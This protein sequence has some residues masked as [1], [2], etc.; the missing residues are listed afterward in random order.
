MVSNSVA[1]QRGTDPVSA[2]IQ[3]YWGRG[4]DGRP[5]AFVPD[6]GAERHWFGN[7][8]RVGDR[9]LLFLNRVRSTHT[10]IGFESTG[11][12]AW[13]VENP[14]VE[15]S[16]WRMRRLETPANPVGVLLGFAAV[17]R[18][19]EYVIALGSADPI[20]SHPIY[21]ARWPAANVRQGQLQAPEWWAGYRLGWVSDASSV[22][23]WPLFENGQSELSLHLDPATGRFLA[24][25]TQGFG[26]A[27]V[28]MRA[29]PALTGPWSAPRF[30]FRPP[31]YVRPNAMIYAAKAHPE[32]TG[33]DLT[34]TYATN[35]FQFAEHLTDSLIYYPRFVRVVRSR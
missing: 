32:L 13:M 31:E 15:P 19:G 30:L 23:R 20:K 2:S 33:G 7:G 34:L 17:V 18:E 22:P 9:L 25:Q 10:G 35:T 21:A 11:W 3:F 8:V 4:A 1:I 27:D 28:I 24:V 14:D 5:A 29:A 12:T 26:A 16:E 6:A